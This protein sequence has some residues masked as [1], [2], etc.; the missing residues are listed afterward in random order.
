MPSCALDVS[1]S[2]GSA[3]MTSASVTESIAIW[4]S[5]RAVVSTVAVTRSRV[6][7]LNPASAALI[8]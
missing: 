4:K 6:I 3:T 5:T 8:R 2:G 7:V 1:T